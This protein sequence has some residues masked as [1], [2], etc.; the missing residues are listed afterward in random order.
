MIHVD[1]K[2]GG[3][4]ILRTALGLSA[5]TGKECTIENI[6]SARANPGLQEQHLQ[7]VLAMQK[8]CSAEL[9]GAEKGSTKVTFIPNKI[10]KGDLEVKIGTAGSV[11]LILQILLIPA[12]KTNLSIHIKGGATYGK[13]APPIHHF[14]NVFFPLLK[15]MNYDC[16]VNIVRHGFFPKGGADVEVFSPQATLQP[17]HIPEKG[18]LVRIKGISIA[19]KHL[20]KAQVA[21]RQAKEAK[22][23][24]FKKFPIPMHIK[25]EYV[26]ALDA[27]SGVQLTIETE[28]SIFGGDALG[29]KGKPAEQVAKEAVTS[30]LH[31]YENGTV[32]IHSADMLLPYI[33]LAGGSYKA[34]EITDHIRT[35]MKVIEQ[36]LDV[37]FKIKNGFISALYI[38]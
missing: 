29:E 8:L 24:L 10:R 30:L 26:D 1:G 34:P 14:E 20:E 21:E 16:T 19:S 9:K 4:Q 28:N 25:T 35:N 17:L 31:S 18:K 11:G 38:K 22:Q 12:M 2:E 6:R 23:L 36:F 3:G 27:G 32:D 15:K 13:F 37:K 7:G 5:I 33:A